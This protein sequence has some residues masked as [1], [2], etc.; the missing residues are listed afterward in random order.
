MAD[1]KITALPTATS[2]LTTDL[3]VFVSDPGGTPITKAITLAN[4]LKLSITSVAIQVKTVG[5]GTYTPT[6]GMRFALVIATGGGGSSS[7]ATNTDSVTGGGGAGGTA[8]KL[9]TAAQVGVSKAYTVGAGGIRANPGGNGLNTTWNTT[10]I[11]ANGGVASAAQLTGATTNTGAGGAGGTATGGDINITGG[12]GGPGFIVNTTNGL[13]GQGGASFWG[14]GAT[15]PTIDT[16]GVAGACYGS[17]ASGAHAAGATD[18]LGANGADGVI[19]IIE[20]IG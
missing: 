11:V 16:A 15:L 8:I 7:D 17:G 4:L 1:T 14:G 18:R 19:Y 5:S 3:G 2:A 6:S 13:G 10:D 9:F 20:F 12:S